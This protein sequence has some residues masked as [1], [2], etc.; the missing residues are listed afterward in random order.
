MTSCHNNMH[1]YN[2]SAA[3]ECNTGTGAL[4][5][6]CDRASGQCQCK[7][8]YGGRQCYECRDGYWYYPDCDGE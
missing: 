2:I 8:N 7:A 1:M 5:D 4:D 6:I 3:C